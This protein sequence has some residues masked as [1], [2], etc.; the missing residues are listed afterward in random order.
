MKTIDK[1]NIMFGYFLFFGI[2]PFLSL[3]CGFL[4]GIGVMK[5]LGI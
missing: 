1:F 3:I 2:L 4:I 5:L